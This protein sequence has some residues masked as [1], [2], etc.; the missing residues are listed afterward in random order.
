MQRGRRLETERPSRLLMSADVIL[1]ELALGG[2]AMAQDLSAAEALGRTVAHVCLIDNEVEI[3]L[4]RRDRAGSLIGLG[5]WAEWQVNEG[6]N[7]LALL[8]DGNVLQ[9]GAGGSVAAIDGEVTP[10]VC[11]EGTEELLEAVATA[12]STH[13][14]ALLKA[15]QETGH[16]ASSVE[17]LTIRGNYLAERNADLRQQLADSEAEHERQKALIRAAGL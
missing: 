12:G 6:E 9:H 10:I 13:A 15:L 1:V 14:E 7:G 5:D 17:I 3:V 8:K 16:V 2:E 4:M 11:V